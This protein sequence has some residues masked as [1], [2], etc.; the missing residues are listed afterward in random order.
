MSRRRPSPACPRGPHGRQ[1]RPPRVTGTSRERVIS[2][3]RVMSWPPWSAQP[4]T[5]DLRI[6]ITLTGLDPPAGLV[7]RTAGHAGS[8]EEPTAEPVE[9]AGWL[10]L[11]WVLQ[12]LTSGGSPDLESSPAS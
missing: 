8:G 11:F 5:I 3:A 7:V 12:A 10:G 1:L 2:R 9:F 6:V 4:E